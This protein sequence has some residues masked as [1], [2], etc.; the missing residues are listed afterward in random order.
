MGYCVLKVRHLCLASVCHTI[1]MH[2]SKLLT[3]DAPV[4]RQ[5]HISRWQSLTAL[6]LL[7]LQIKARKLHEL[8]ANGVPD[9]YQAE[10]A[11]MRIKSAK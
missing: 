10:L 11:R 7:L 5:I 2:V 3:G 8:A 9:K 4:R 6:P 1:H